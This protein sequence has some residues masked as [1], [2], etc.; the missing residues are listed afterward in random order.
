MKIFVSGPFNTSDEELK[1][2]RVKT[3]SKYCSDLFR[4]GITPVSALLTGLKIAE[5]NNL[6]TDTNTWV[7]YSE[8]MVEGCNE[9]HVL[10]IDGYLESSGIKAEIN[11]AIELNIL[12]KYIPFELCC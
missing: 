11:K 4:L 1:L 8:D 7:K 6:P 5:Y 10:M 9:L 3:I 12:V 2:K